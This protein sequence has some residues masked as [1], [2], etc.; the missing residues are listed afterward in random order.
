MPFK[1]GNKPIE[2]NGPSVY[3]EDLGPG[4]LGQTNKNGTIAINLKLSP[5]FVDEVIEHEKVH[6]NQISRG[7]LTYDDDNIYWKGKK[8]NKELHMVRNSKDTPWEKEAY[9]KSNTK[10]GDTKYN[11]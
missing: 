2:L 3:Y 1:L 7:D 4:V 6:I 9:T 5:K 8:F 11:I 10:H